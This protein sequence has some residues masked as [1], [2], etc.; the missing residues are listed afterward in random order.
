M[1][2][3]HK[4]NRSEGCSI[5]ATKNST[6]Q[7]RPWYDHYPEECYCR[8][9]RLENL[10]GRRGYVCNPCVLYIKRAIQSLDNPSKEQLQNP[11]DHT[12]VKKKRGCVDMS[13][14]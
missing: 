1:A 11:P 4:Y 3:N 6:S 7:F 9:F 5:C 10:D 12:K 2:C 13:V 8:V 14:A